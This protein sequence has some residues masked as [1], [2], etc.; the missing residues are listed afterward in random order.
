MIYY[1]SNGRV[2]DVLFYWILV[3]AFVFAWRGDWD[4]HLGAL[5]VGY[6]SVNALIKKARS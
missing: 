1:R 4:L 5:A 3:M 6:L 2:F